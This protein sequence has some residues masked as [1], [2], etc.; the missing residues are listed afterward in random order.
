MG[1]HTYD[2]DRA[3]ALDDP[4]RFR[5]CSAEELLGA[6]RPA[7]SET[8]AD[9][10]SGTGFYT[11]VVAGHVDRVYAVDVQPVMHDHYRRK[12]VPEGVT[13]M[14]A[15]IETL[16][17]SADALDAVVSTMTYHEFAGDAALDE[18]AR[19]LAPGGRLVTVDWS[20]AGGDAGPP[21]DERFALGEAVRAVE[22][23]GFR[24]VRA[25]SRTET[26]VHVAVR[27]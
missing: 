22:D 4:E 20:A 7:T 10:G 18:L 23:A 19:V 2:A 21:T 15:E 5:H 12:G 14:T 27:R 8:V 13:P 26:F 17:L 1:F 24:T 6:L 25:D 16:P 3:A 11:D 9:L